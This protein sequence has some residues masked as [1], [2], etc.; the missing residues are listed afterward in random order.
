MFV[1]ICYVEGVFV[2][3]CSPCMP[4]NILN[5]PAYAILANKET[6]YDFHIKVEVTD[7]FR[8]CRECGSAEIVS[9]GCRL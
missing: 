8:L 7:P 5:L 4:S 3:K 1:V 2:C 6:E 9:N